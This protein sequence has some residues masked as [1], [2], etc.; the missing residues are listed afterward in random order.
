MLGKRQGGGT[1]DRARQY[2]AGG[3]GQRARVM[4]DLVRGKPL[5][6]GPKTSPTF[7]TARMPGLRSSVCP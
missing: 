1:Q 5:W 2:L 4:F 7:W 3:R 6:I